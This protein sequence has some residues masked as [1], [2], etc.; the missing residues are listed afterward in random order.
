ME[1]RISGAALRHA[2]DTGN[3][4]SCGKI[5]YSNLARARRGLARMLRKA[6]LIPDK[7]G[8]LVPYRCWRCRKY[9]VG[10]TRPKRTGNPCRPAM[11]VTT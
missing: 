3:E 11:G 2:R 5:Q 9:H 8:V 10:H 4:V 6:E 1:R 7:E